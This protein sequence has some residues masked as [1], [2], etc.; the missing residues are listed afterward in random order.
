V[1][2]AIELHLKDKALL[3]QIQCFFGGVGVIR[4]IGSKGTVG[5]TVTKIKDIITVIV[6]HFIKNPLL[7]QKRADFELFKWVVQLMD[8]KEHLSYEGLIKILAI[9]A[10]L[11]L[12]LSDELKAAF[13]NIIPVPRPLVKDQNIQEGSPHWLAGFV[14]GDG[15]FYVGISESDRYVAGGQVLIRFFI[16]QHSRDTSLLNSLSGFFGPTP[17]GYVSVVKDPS[18]ALS[19]FT[20]SKFSDIEEKIIPFFKKYPFEGSKNPSDFEDWCKIALLI[21]EKAHLTQEGL[22]KIRLIKSG[23]NTGREPRV[24]GL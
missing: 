23:M 21:K 6:P 11:N 4:D 17:C 16:T 20:V 9:K 24:E 3:E 14:D 2:F 1:E 10:S 19:Y 18:K 13:P 22:N 12:G 8:K 15:C 5:Y 7:T